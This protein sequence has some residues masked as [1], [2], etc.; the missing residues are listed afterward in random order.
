MNIDIAH[1]KWTMLILDTLHQW[2]TCSARMSAEELHIT[3]VRTT[4]EAAA[5]RAHSAQQCEV[6][7]VLRIAI[8][9]SSHTFDLSSQP[10]VHL[11]ASRVP[12]EALCKIRLDAPTHSL[13]YPVLIFFTTSGSTFP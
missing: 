2:T 4:I 1:R 3:T 12:S 13:W 11:K 10:R 7:C 8:G 5:L 6:P 9:P